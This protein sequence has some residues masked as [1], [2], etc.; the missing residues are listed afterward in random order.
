[1][2][3]VIRIDIT[4]KTKLSEKKVENNRCRFITMT[5]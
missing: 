2:P 3:H 4:I 5:N 1:M